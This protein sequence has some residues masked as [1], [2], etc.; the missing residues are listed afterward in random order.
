MA[1]PGFGSMLAGARDLVLSSPS[2]FHI[3][4]VAAGATAV[5]LLLFFFLPWGGQPHLPTWTAHSESESTDL[6]PNHIHFVYILSDSNGDFNFQFSYFLSIYAA[7]YHWKPEA[8]FLHTNARADGGAVARAR[9]GKSGKWA[10]YIFTLFDMQI[11]TVPVP[12]H[13]DNG[14]KIGNMEHKSDFVR[15]KAIHD[16]GGVY[17]DFDVHALRD[18]SYLRKSGFEAVAG[19][20]KDGAVNSG[21][22]MSAKGGK[23]IALWMMGMHEVYDGQ[24]TTHSNDVITRYGD[25]LVRQPG[26]MLIMEREAFAPGGW[27]ADDNDML[28]AVHNETSNLGEDFAQGAPLPSHEEAFF[29]RWEHRDR[30]PEWERDFSSSYLLHAFSPGRFNHQV[31]GFEHIT[32]RYVLERQSNFAR[33]TYPIAKLM[34]ERGLIDINDSHL[35]T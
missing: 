22:F 28:F 16:F 5:L 8:I 20:Q 35:G 19:R 31:P 30:F 3:R 15:V 34:Y 1:S 13:A 7:W 17:I 25:R 33:A 12:T 29:D 4:L 24:W 23:M 21:T 18:I 32:P 6:I 9:Q 14:K 26:Q 27:D 10:K 11:N 2:R